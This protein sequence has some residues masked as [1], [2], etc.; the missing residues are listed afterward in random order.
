MK[1]APIQILLVCLMASVRKVGRVTSTLTAC[2]F[3]EESSAWL[4]KL[5]LKK[6][7]IFWIALVGR[8]SCWKWNPIVFCNP[9]SWHRPFLHWKQRLLQLRNNGSAAV[10]DWWQRTEWWHVIRAMYGSTTNCQKIL[11]APKKDFTCS[12]CIIENLWS[13]SRCY[14]ANCLLLCWIAVQKTG[15]YCQC[16]LKPCFHCHVQM[17]SHEKAGHVDCQFSAPSERQEMTK[18][19]MY[20][21]ISDQSINR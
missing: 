19:T 11:R 20:W 15:C 7:R 16:K 8:F 2:I 18:S 13:Q 21:S 5:V 14:S 6:L 3:G 1:I 4:N 12:H 10:V 17:S 9:F